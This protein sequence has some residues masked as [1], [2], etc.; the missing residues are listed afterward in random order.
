MTGSHQSPAASAVD[1]AGKNW[2]C[3]GI[4]LPI[5]G[6]C[7]GRYCSLVR[8]GVGKGTQAKLLMSE[9]GIPQISTGD[10]LRDQRIRRTDLGLLA[11]GLMSKGQLVP[12]DLVNRMVEVRLKQ[13]DCGNGYILD[14]F[15]RTIAQAGV[16]G[17]VSGANQ[18]GA[19]ADCGQPYRRVSRCCCDG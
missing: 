7:R 18:P 4:L 8:L 1:G 12:D 13:P 3:K 17:W 14:G 10:I 11:D 9:F 2:R 16:A 6:L 15:P 5:C 19:T